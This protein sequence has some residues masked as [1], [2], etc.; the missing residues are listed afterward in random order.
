MGGMVLLN[1]Q[2]HDQSYLSM[3]PKT[4]KN[5]KVLLGPITSTI[6][7]V[8]FL[9]C[10]FFQIQQWPCHNNIVTDKG[11][12]L[13]EDCTPECVYLCP[14]EEECTSFSWGH[15]KMY[16]PGTIANSQTDRTPAKMNKNGDAAKVT[17]LVELGILYRNA[18]FASYLMLMLF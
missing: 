2:K 9:V 13:F 4:N 5:F 3:I 15:S 14:H 18:S 17:I 8:K 1:G 11:L 12:N 10:I 16:T 6:T 7:T